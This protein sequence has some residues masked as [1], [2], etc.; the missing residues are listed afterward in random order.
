[1]HCYLMVF[2]MRKRLCVGVN[3]TV[4]LRRVESCDFPLQT[5]SEAHRTCCKVGTR[6]FLPARLFQCELKAGVW[7]S[8]L[9]TPSLGFPAHGA[10]R[11]PKEDQNCQTKLPKLNLPLLQTN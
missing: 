7:D 10:M 5:H 9:G 1:M 11:L 6:L 8:L 2:L 3:L 4:V